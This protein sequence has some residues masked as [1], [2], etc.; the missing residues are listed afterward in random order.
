MPRVFR[1]SRTGCL[2]PADY[3]EEWGRKYGIGLGP[4][5]VS[6]ALTNQYDIPIAEAHDQRKTM[7]PV[8]CCRAQV[9]LVDVSVE[10]WNEKKAILAIEDKDMVTRGQLMRTKQLA[11]SVMMQR[12]FPEEIPAKTLPK[13]ID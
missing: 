11:K 6:E 9:D 10:E 7:H 5:P 8:G 2:Y 4:T 3:V 13:S 12:F 1:C